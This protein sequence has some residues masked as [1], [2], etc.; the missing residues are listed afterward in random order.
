MLTFTNFTITVPFA[1]FSAENWEALVR[2][3]TNP[4][5]TSWD[6]VE[7]LILRNAHWGT[8]HTLKNYVDQV[9]NGAINHYNGALTTTYNRIATLEAEVT[10]LWGELTRLS[11][12][13][14]ASKAKVPEPPTF[15]GS[16]NKMHLHDWLS[17]IALYCSVSSIIT[18][19]QKIVCTLTRLR[20]PASTYMK[21]Y[22]DKVQAGQGVGSWGDFA[23]EL[24][25]IY[26][27]RDNKE[28][29]KKELTVLWVNKD[30]AKKNFV[31][32]AE[33]YRT[34]ARIVNYSNE[35]HIDKMKEVIPDK[36]RNALVIYEITNQSL[37]TWNNYLKLLMQAYKALYL[38]K[39]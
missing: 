17:Q 25:N 4:K 26:R 38:N 30:L 23:Q 15:A 37:K 27:Q 5:N 11:G 16:E 22:Y 29:A 19:N 34:L 35:V 7:M 20:A 21:S 8:T 2:D 28:G 39:A 12:G 1:D 14:V 24:K 33:R 31:K 10:C 6:D 32:Y 9:L 13:N 36:L 18:D 3:S